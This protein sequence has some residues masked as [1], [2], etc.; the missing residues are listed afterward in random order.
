MVT[1]MTKLKL[2]K[3]FGGE[4]VLF[5]IDVWHCMRYCI[6]LCLNSEFRDASR[7]ATESIRQITNVKHVQ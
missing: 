4:I 1:Y 5:G 7:D 6:P 3:E 2:D